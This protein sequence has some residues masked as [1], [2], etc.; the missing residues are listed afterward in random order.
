MLSVKQGG[1][2]KHFL[3]LWCDMTWDW[4]PVSRAI[5]EH[6]M[7]YSNIYTDIDIDMEGVCIYLYLPNVAIK[8]SISKDVYSDKY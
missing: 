6:S 8:A 2:K 1:I 3:N 5:G 4:T 7:H